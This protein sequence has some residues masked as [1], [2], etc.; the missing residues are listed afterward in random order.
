ML[1]L[2]G[3]I[4]FATD[5]PPG[6]DPGALLRFINFLKSKREE[7]LHPPDLRMVSNGQN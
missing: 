7:D 2:V 3:L 6:F 5:P 4:D 1:G